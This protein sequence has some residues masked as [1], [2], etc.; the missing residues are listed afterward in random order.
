[1]LG[2]HHDRVEA[3]RLVVLILDGDLSL[4]VRAKPLDDVLPA[5]LR[6]PA[7]ELVRQVDRHRHEL[8]GLVDGVA[9]H[10]TLVASPLLLIGAGVD[11]H[12]DVRRLLLDGS[13]DSTGIGIEAHRRV[14]VANLCDRLSHDLRDLDVRLRGDLTATDDKAGLDHGLNRNARFRVLREV[15]VEQRIA[16]LVTDFVWVT[17]GHGLG[18]E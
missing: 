4:T 3:K 14:R 15:G 5:D 13:Q 8:S 1:V 7:R 18:S 6:E 9:E 17:L 10:E 16:D 2:R 12:G 11:A